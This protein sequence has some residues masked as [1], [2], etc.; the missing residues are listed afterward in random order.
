MVERLERVVHREDDLVLRDYLAL[1]DASVRTSYFL[2]T[3]AG[4]PLATLTVKLESGAVPDL[5]RRARRSRRSCT[6]S[7]SRASTSASGASPGEGSGG[8]TD[9]TTSRTEILGLAEAQVK[10]NAI[11]VPTGAKGGFVCRGS[12]SPSPAGVRAAYET[13]IGALLDI[14]DNLVDGQVVRP[15]GVVGLDGDDPYLV[16]AAD[17]GTATFSDAAN[18]LADAHGFW[19]GDAFASGGSHGYDHKA[20][21]I[22]ARGAWVAVRRHFHQL[23]IDVQTEA[24]RVA[25]VGD[26]SRGCVRQRHAPEPDDRARG[27]LRPPPHL[28]RTPGPTRSDR[29]TNVAASPPSARR[30]GTTTTAA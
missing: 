27:R 1:V 4:R 25:G 12:T 18:E 17:R 14:T 10:K 29:S 11:I 23:G 6:A 3:P 8:A 20:M 28:H 30:A 13:F 16:V 22:T 5:R 26:M 2:R 9:R 19:L 21:G 24:V 7:G 15:A